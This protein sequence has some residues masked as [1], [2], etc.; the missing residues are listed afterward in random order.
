MVYCIVWALVCSSTRWAMWAMIPP[1]D[2]AICLGFPLLIFPLRSDGR[3]WIVF[4]PLTNSSRLTPVVMPISHWC[5][6]ARRTC[7][8]SAFNRVWARVGDGRT[9][10][11]WRAERTK[12]RVGHPPKRGDEL[13]GRA[14][15]VTRKESLV[16]WLSVGASRTY[17]GG[18]SHGWAPHTK[19]S[20]WKHGETLKVGSA[21][22]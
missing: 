19:L 5:G 8:P 1:F 7:P 16:K 4:S 3:D 20:S 18:Q 6:R 10:G 17:M 2:L 13:A 12:W 15:K 9:M 22:P 14:G 21:W 11:G